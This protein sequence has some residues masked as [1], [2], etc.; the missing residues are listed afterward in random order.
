MER[1][2]TN[3][4]IKNLL[5]GLETSSKIEL[6]EEG[7]KELTEL[8]K[9]AKAKGID[10]KN[11]TDLAGIKAIMLL[12][13]KANKNGAILPEKP[14]LKALPTMIGKPL[15]LGH[16]RNLC[17][18]HI[19]HYSYSKKTKKAIMYGVIYKSN[20]MDEWSEMQKDFKS[21]S[22]HV[23]YE[24]WTPKDKRRELKDGTYELL[25]QEIAGCAILF[26]D[27]E[28]AVD[29]AKV[30]LLAKKISTQTPELVYAKKYKSDE[31]I[32]CKDGK[33]ELI[34]SEVDTLDTEKVEEVV[35][36]VV[37]PVVT[38]EAV[39]PVSTK[40][41]CSACKEVFEKPLAGDIKCPKCLVILDSTGAVLYPA[42]IQDFKCSCPSCKADGWLI[43]SNNEKTAQVRCRYCAKTYKLEFAEPVSSEFIDKLSF[44]RTG[45]VQCYQCHTTIYYSGVSGH[46]GKTVKCPKCKL[47][48]SFD[49]TN[50]ETRTINKIEEIKI[51]KK[52]S[53]KEN[54]EELDKSL[55][56]G[57]QEGNMD[58]PKEIV[59]KVLASE[60]KK[61][62]A[63]AEET[64]AEEAT[65]EEKPKVV[66]EVIEETTEEAKRGKG[67]GTGGVKQKDGGA[68]VCVCP[69][70]GKTSTHIKGT[71]CSK[72]KCPK[73]NTSMIGKQD[74][75]EK[76]KKEKYY[77][78]KNLRKAIHKMKSKIKT[79]KETYEAKVKKLVDDIKIITANLT[80]S[81]KEISQIL[82]D[83][84]VEI[85]FYKEKAKTIVERQAELGET[86]LTDEEILNDDKFELAKMTK[87]ALLLKASEESE[88]L[89]D[90]G[91]KKKDGTWYSKKQEAINKVAFGDK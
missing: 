43:L 58:I 30:L 1:K 52:S 62:E 91:N 53:E 70:C 15:N 42:Q 87:N 59:E 10:L 28:P 44:V 78:T 37:A 25:Q 22:L 50:K 8:E 76:V 29:E 13:G 51:T 2:L 41:T 79:Q 46:S 90:A 17:I 75:I 61:E 31:I 26:G 71:P 74:K 18:G 7:S 72:I 89:E 4:D 9:I 11:N 32:T 64:K 66:E 68:N 56:E 49:L 86:S 27:T 82:K 39:T 80:T 47:E 84:K 48:F 81:K 65:I 5:K 14:F 85:E 24:I 21:N 33:C 54:T 57:N 77:K 45:S 69:K 88:E 16:Q 12:T 36:T 83:S 3:I 60:K 20:F 35:D 67:K 19:I 40:I 23:S 38:P 63:K 6:L 34:T 55:N 73:C